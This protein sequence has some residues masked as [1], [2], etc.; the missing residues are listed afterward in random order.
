MDPH[1]SYRLRRRHFL[2]GLTAWSAGWSSV[3]VLSWRS[4][5]AGP[6]FMQRFDFDRAPGLFDPRF[7][8]VASLYDGTAT[9][10]RRVVAV[11]G[12][13]ELS[14]A[15][16]GAR[17]GDDIVLTSGTYTAAHQLT[18]SGTASA[19]IRLIGASSFGSVL[20]GGF[21]VGGAYVMVL[22]VAFRAKAYRHTGD[23][24]SVIAC[25]FRD[26]VGNT[27]NPGILLQANDCHIA[28]NDFSMP[29]AVGLRMDFEGASK[30][31]R[32]RVEYNYIHDFPRPADGHQD[33]GCEGIQLGTYGGD[34]AE[35][36]NECVINSNLFQDCDRDDEPI[37]VKSAGGLL[38]GNHF[39]NCFGSISLRVTKNCIVN[40]N[41]VDGNG[42]GVKGIVVNG[43]DNILIGNIC[44]GDKIFR[45]D[46]GNET[47]K[48]ITPGEPDVATT[49][50]LIAES[51]T[52]NWYIGDTWQRVVYQADVDF[53]GPVGGTVTTS[54]APTIDY[55]PA[56]SPAPV[57]QARPLATTDV[58][59]HA[60][61]KWLL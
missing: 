59:P 29:D 6:H 16:A 54:G 9:R 53:K 55:L 2:S 27:G 57:S 58:G 18:A 47:Y 61:M 26:N 23:F 22:G 25:R 28:F 31:F 4:A 15:L 49:Q 34:N 5:S 40:H 38:I 19:P 8:H 30:C 1:I 44:A 3:S 46:A 42:K 21:H 43:P 50:R 60:L 52:G 48:T 32:T 37:A 20:S 7:I 56:S 13:G 33:N 17:A 11:S 51:N 36:D 24:G 45:A 12:D 41:Y 35:L 10:G 39:E 14:S